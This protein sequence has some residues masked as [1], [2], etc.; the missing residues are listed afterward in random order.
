MGLHRFVVEIEVDALRVD[1]AE[2]IS[3]AVTSWGGQFHPDNVFFG[4]SEDAVC[5]YMPSVRS[6]LKAL[7]RKA[8]REKR[9][10]QKRIE[11]SQKRGSYVRR[12]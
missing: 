9:I 6:V 11:A 5:V 3:D 4:L 1:A 2:Y 7:D 12:K 8:T 10:E